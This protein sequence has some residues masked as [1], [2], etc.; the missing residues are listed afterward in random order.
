MRFNIHILTSVHNECFR[1]SAFCNREM[2]YLLIFKRQESKKQR[3]ASRRMTNWTKPPFDLVQII[4][5]ED[6]YSFKYDYRQL[7]KSY[8]KFRYL[9]ANDFAT[10]T[11]KGILAGAIVQLH[12][13]Y[14][15]RYRLVGWLW[16][17]VTFSDISAI[18][19]RNRCPVSKF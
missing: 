14:A 7:I 18:K 1:D 9:H 4:R 15:K 5:A 6:W 16:F 8:Y 2:A 3:T 11:G 19:W 13:R 10:D 12:T 17:N